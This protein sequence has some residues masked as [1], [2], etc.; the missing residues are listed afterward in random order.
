MLPGEDAQSGMRR[1]L[2]RLADVEEGFLEAARQLRFI[3]GLALPHNQGAPAKRTQSA[4]RL[5]VAGDVLFK[6]RGPEG[7]IAFRRIR[8]AAS[9]VPVPEAPMHE[10]NRAMPRQD[11]VWP[12]GKFRSIQSESKSEAMKNGPNE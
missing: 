3:D 1:R 4:E 7:E 8:E 10:H 9:G 2:R 5:L 6:L 12:A 11:D